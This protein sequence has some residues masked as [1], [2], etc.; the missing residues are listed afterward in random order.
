MSDVRSQEERAALLARYRT[1]ADAVAAALKGLSDADLD[2]SS[3]PDEWTPRMVA[4]HLADSETTAFVRLRRL[5]A[6]DNPQIVGYDEAEFARRLHYNRPI[7]ASLEV[8]RAVR[9]AS[10]ELLEGLTATEWE[11]SGTHTQSGRYSVDDWLSIYA[12]HPH[13]HAEQIRSS[14][15]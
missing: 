6:E 9:A 10:L 13:D 2:R 15:V 12:A 8:L 1:G 5:I 3:G 7:A 4:H 11:R 14:Q